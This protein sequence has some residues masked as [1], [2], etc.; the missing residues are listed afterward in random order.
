[1]APITGA[2]DKSGHVCSMMQWEARLG[3][4]TLCALLCEAETPCKPAC[5]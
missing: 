1:M 2:S 3:N 5:R 4:C